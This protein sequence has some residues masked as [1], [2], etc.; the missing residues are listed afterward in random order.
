[1]RLFKGNVPD[2]TEWSLKTSFNFIGQKYDV[3]VRDE[4]LENDYINLKVILSTG[5]DKKANFK[6]TWDRKRKCFFYRSKGYP[7]VREHKD[8]RDAVIKALGDFIEIPAKREKGRKFAGSVP[9]DGTLLGVVKS[10]ENLS[11]GIYKRAQ[12]NDNFL[13]F[14]LV[15]ATGVAKKANYNINYKLSEFDFV[16]SKDFHAFKRDFNEDALKL[17]DDNLFDS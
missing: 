4:T 7:Y 3:Y 17:I 12:T 11:F 15:L 1:M 10:K 8:F 5:V 16:S 13:S 6:L 2:L 14:K 9:A